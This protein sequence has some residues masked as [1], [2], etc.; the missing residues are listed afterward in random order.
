MIILKVGHKT[1]AYAVLLFYLVGMALFNI[2]Y[3][4]WMMFDI[5]VLYCLGGLAGPALQGI[6]STQVPP[7]EQG[8]LQCTLT[9]IMNITAIMGPP[10]M[11][12]LFKWFTQPQ[13]SI[14][15]PGAHFLSAAGFCF[16]SLLLAFRSLR[17]Y[18]AP[19]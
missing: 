3:Q 15:F 6:I 2:A 10:L 4:G 18:V 7:S 5:L 12:N 13:F 1:A 8:E 16:I 9:G 19:K 17:H 11:T 14:F